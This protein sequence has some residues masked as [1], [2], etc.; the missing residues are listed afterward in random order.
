MKIAISG[1]GGVGKTTLAGTLARLLSNQGFSVIAVDA[2][3][4]AN[5]GSAIGFT[6][7]EIRHVQP[8]AEM[9][10]LIE[11]RT[12]AKPGAL[13]GIFKLNPVVSDIPETYSLKKD[14]I[15]LLTL[16]RAKKGGAGCYCPE[17]VFL[18]RLLSHLILQSHEVVI[19]DMEAGIEHL[20]RGTTGGV[21]AFIVVVEPG[22]RSLQ[23][24]S[25]VRRMAHDL[26]IK[27]IFVVGN[28]VSNPE[29]LAFLKKEFSDDEFLGALSF[30]R[31]VI[32]A[33]LKGISPYDAGSG[34][35]AET[36][37]ILDRLFVKIKKK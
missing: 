11:E 18:K 23:T 16:G 13:G 19:L 28:K 35:V 10:H 20:S 26:G 24:A 22:K 14:H 30:D 9:S 33:D 36:A 8:I 3:P 31:T 37:G 7:E 15:R 27:S 6:Q 1:K 32:D 17:G 5:L 12:G 29:E 25:D 4:D 34:V 2:D 21:D